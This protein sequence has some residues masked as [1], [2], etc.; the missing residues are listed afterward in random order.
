MKRGAVG[1]ALAGTV[2]VL[3]CRKAAPNPVAEA[4]GEAEVAVGAVSLRDVQLGNAL[5]EGGQVVMPV[6]TFDAHDTIYA[7]IAT[8]EARDSVELVARWVFDRDGSGELIDSMAQTLPP[9]GPANIEFHVANQG[10]WPAGSY[11]VELYVED[12]PVATR[13]FDVR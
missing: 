3:A 6:T 7:A 12:K 5:G 2:A 1:L 9:G 13:E 4:V 8:G 10:G 11:R